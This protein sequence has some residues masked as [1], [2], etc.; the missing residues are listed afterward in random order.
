MASASAARPWS[1]ASARIGVAFGPLHDVEVPAAD[2]RR[3]ELAAVVAL[4]AV[5][6]DRRRV[7]HVG[8]DRVAEDQELDDRR[9]EHEPGHARIAEDLAQLLAHHPADASESGAHQSSSLRNERTA[10]ARPTNRE[11][12]HQQRLVAQ[13][14]D[15]DPLEEDA[16]R[17][18]QKVA[19]RNEVGDRPQHRRH[20]LDREHEA[21]EEEGGEEGGDERDLGGEHLRARDGGDEEA[22][23]EAAAKEE[24]RERQSSRALPRSGTPKSTTPRSDTAATSTRPIAR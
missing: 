3:D 16:A 1:R 9:D 6:H 13:D 10:S 19:R 17:H 24:E 12:E 14:R 20:V 15:P 21:R 2:Q 8:R 11:G 4:V 5:E 7:P 18:H 22:E 23:A